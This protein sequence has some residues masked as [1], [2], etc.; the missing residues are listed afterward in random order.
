MPTIR[1]S[2]TIAGVHIVEPTLINVLWMEAIGPH[3]DPDG[4][5]RGN[6]RW[7]R[8]LRVRQGF[9][10]RSAVENW[11]FWGIIQV[12]N[13]PVPVLFPTPATTTT[14]GRRTGWT[15]VK[16]RLSVDQRALWTTDRYVDT[17]TSISHPLIG[18]TY[19]AT[20]FL[21]KP[22]SGYGSPLTAQVPEIL[23]NASPDCV[24]YVR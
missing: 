14:R 23:V 11:S 20:S 15:R 10:I 21:E 3:T 4:R 12:G 17:Q 19:A 24:N 8:Q 13:Y 2:D 16:R 22:R 7:I 1:E 6:R 5:I 9:T 18:V